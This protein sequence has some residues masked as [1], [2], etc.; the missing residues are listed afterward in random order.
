MLF[1]FLLWYNN[2][3]DYMRI[4]IDCDATPSIDL[5]IEL[6]RSYQIPVIIYADDSHLIDK[7]VNIVKSC[8]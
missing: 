8:E 1:S 7:D 5:I 3:G 6:A 2:I 4:I